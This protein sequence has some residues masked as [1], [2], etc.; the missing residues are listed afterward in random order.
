MTQAKV[1]SQ[2]DLT[3]RSVPD[4]RG[5]TGL[6]SLMDLLAERQLSDKAKQDLVRELALH[7]NI[8]VPAI[9]RNN[10]LTSVLGR[11]TWSG[12]IELGL[13]IDWAETLVH[14]FAH[15]IVHCRNPSGF[16][17]SPHGYEFNSALRDAAVKSIELLGLPMPEWKP[18]EPA[19]FQF[20]LGERVQVNPYR[21][22]HQPWFGTVTGF[23]VHKVYVLRE[24]DGSKYQCR[25]WRIAP[26]LLAPAELQ[27]VDIEGLEDELDALIAESL[28]I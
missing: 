3:K 8:P 22:N 4:Q 27:D 2:R 6:F 14:E 1:D 16:G 26:N 11:C 24:E 15:H 7:F 23:T 12:T 20:E 5:H 13:G 18:V 21:P 10:R 19:H 25:T 28:D 9:E 17:V